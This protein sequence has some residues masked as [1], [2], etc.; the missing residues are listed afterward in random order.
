MPWMMRPCQW[1]HVTEQRMGRRFAG[2]LA[3]C[4]L[5][6][7][8]TASLR[9]EP[10]ADRVDVFKAGEGGYEQYRI[11]GLVV[12]PKG[13]LLAYC[14]ARAKPLSDWG[15]IDL[16]YRRS[17]DGG[18][19]WDAPRPLAKPPAD[20][21]KNPV[22]IERKVG[23]PDGITMNNP[24]AISDAAAG[25]VH[26]LYCVEYARCF[27]MRSTDDGVT[28]SEPVEITATFEK[29]RDRHP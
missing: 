26:V 6:L 25:V 21:K 16:L 1:D 27:Y 22:A 4:L 29:F 11:P 17:T 10:A 18:R 28:F 7:P 8:L 20:A 24:V 9:A 3:G 12:T 23:N 2:V 13:S 15:R 5:V 19:T 14:E